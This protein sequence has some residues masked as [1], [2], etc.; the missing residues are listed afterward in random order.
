MNGK[1]Y[2]SLITR[3]IHTIWHSIDEKGPIRVNKK[4][5]LPSLYT[6]RGMVKVR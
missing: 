6:S 1:V 2:I 5:E 4:R 3:V